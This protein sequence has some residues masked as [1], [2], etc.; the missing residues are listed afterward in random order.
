MRTLTSLAG[1]VAHLDSFKCQPNSISTHL[2]LFLTWTK[3]LT[4][5]ASF[6]WTYLQVTQMPAFLTSGTK[7]TTHP[8]S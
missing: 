3:H 6:I 1:Y 4:A 2:E 7:G 8:T 5:E